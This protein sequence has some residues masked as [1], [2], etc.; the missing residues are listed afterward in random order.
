MHKKGFTLI[1]LS[2]VLVIIGLLIGGILVAQSM[3]ETTKVNSLINQFRQY[4]IGA[5]L[6]RSTYKAWPGDFDKASTVFGTGIC[7]LNC[8]GTGDGISNDTGSASSFEALLF[9]HQMQWAKTMDTNF[10]FPADKTSYTTWSGTTI[11]NFGYKDSGVT[12]AAPHITQLPECKTALQ[13]GKVMPGLGTNYP[14]AHYFRGHATISSL[15]GATAAAVDQK[16]DN[17]VPDTGNFVAIN[18][19]GLYCR[20]ASGSGQFF[21][22]GTATRYLIRTNPECTVWYCMGDE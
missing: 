16:I 2:I 19:Q 6:F 13:L 9:F 22:G 1:E 11:P 20:T 5:N 12:F 10:T 7:G 14:I 18:Y 4:Q 8:N 21:N 3:I 15:K 17:G